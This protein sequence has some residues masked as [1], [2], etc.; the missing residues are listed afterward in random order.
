MDTIFSE[1]VKKVISHYPLE[2]KNIYLLSYKG[3]KAVWSIETDIGEVIM[4]KV[5]FAED[6]I[7][8]M[9]HAIDYLRNNGIHTPGVLKTRTGEGFVKL[10]G[11]YF[12]VFEAVHGRQPEYKHENELLMI[13]RGMA[14]F[15]KASK[16]IESPTGKFPSFLLLEWKSDLQRRY[17]RLLSWKE[18]RSQ[19]EE[20]SEFDKKF[21]A[22]ADTFLQQ[23]Q[24][25]LS[26]LD[27]PVFDQWV[28]ETKK[29]KT[30]CHQD[31]AA[32]N[33][34]IGSDDHLYVYDM[35]SL[36]VDLPVRDMRKILNKVMKKRKAWDIELMMKMMKAYQ[37]VNPLTKDQFAILAADI[38]FPHLIYGQVSKYYENREPKWTAQKHISKLSDM[39]A[40]ELSKDAVLQEFLTRL[41]EVIKHG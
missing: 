25:A 29:T 35:D 28:E 26:M 24:T 13:L 8:F 27:N 37:E 2:M 40:T 7:S 33:L 22:H 36:T 16:G 6:H 14:S 4:K 12:V 21:L 32:G 3:K 15:H 39:I 18:Q 11:E 17:E 23:C 34:A 30:L 41:D 10:D 9:I 31:F 5:P 38:Q 20:Q 1:V 19:V